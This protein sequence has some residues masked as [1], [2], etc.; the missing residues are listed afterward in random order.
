MNEQIKE[1]WVKA[2]QSGE[3]KQS[4]GKLCTIKS[5]GT[6]GY[7]CLGVL[8]DLFMKEFPDKLTVKEIKINREQMSYLEYQGI[9]ADGL[10]IN[11]EFLLPNVVNW[12]ELKS[13]NPYV[14]Y[15]NN[16]IM[17][18]TMNDN[19]HSFDEIALTIKH[20]ETL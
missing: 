4:I 16:K 11:D 6:K 14:M 1:L 8:T 13:D 19:G 20:S 5:D 7:C 12:A 18:S 10:F 17:L 3:Y 9:S 2:L 15:M